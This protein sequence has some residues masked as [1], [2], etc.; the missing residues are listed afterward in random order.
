M[1]NITN[2]LDTVRNGV[3]QQREYAEQEL[4]VIFQR[5]KE[6]CEKSLEFIRNSSDCNSDLVDFLDDVL[7]P[8]NFCDNIC[9]DNIGVG[10]CKIKK[11]SNICGTYQV[12]DNVI[13]MHKES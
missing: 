11:S 7:F 3:P 2:L 5:Q 1:K 10:V 6:A 8:Q 9:C 13:T 4:T 12:Y